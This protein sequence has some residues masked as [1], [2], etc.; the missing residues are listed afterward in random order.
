MPLCRYTS[1]NTATTITTTTITTITITTTII[2]II[3]IIIIIQQLN[4]L[5][6][7][8]LFSKIALANIILMMLK[9]ARKK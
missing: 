8:G 2:I 9:R 7:K 1:I 6:L 3:I 4:S 5:L